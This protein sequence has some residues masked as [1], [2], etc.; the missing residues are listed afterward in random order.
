LQLLEIALLFLR[1]SALHPDL[2]RSRL[3]GPGFWDGNY[4]LVQRDPLKKDLC[5]WTKRVCNECEK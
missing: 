3:L 2:P 5:V 1:R 4:H